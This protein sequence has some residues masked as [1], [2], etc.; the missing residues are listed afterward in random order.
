[1]HIMGLACLHK[2]V[3]QS[4]I[5]NI[6]LPTSIHMYLC[7]HT[8]SQFLIENTFLSDTHPDILSHTHSHATASENPNTGSQLEISKLGPMS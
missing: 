7:V 3:S 1:M 2:Y 5:E 8:H 6:S 4:L